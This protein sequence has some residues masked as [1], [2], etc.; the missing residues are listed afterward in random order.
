MMPGGLSSVYDWPLMRQHTFNFVYS[1]VDATQRNC[2]CTNVWLTEGVSALI[3]WVWSVAFTSE[4][5]RLA[6]RC[7]SVKCVDSIFAVVLCAPRVQAGCFR[8]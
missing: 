2:F 5:I 3:F 4:G 1:F 7:A 8:F 6:F